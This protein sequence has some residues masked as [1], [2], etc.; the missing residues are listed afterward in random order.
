I[1]YRDEALVALRKTARETCNMLNSGTGNF[2]LCHGLAGN[3]EILLY[4]KHVLGKEPVSDM[5]DIQLVTDVA[6]TGI[7][8]HSETKVPWPC[9]IQK[10][11]PPGL[12]TGLSG[13]GYF[14]LRLFDSKKNPSILVPI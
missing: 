12:M 7:E 9:G 5:I 6:N 4:G 13:I 11:E 3:C 2:S 8:K 1:I 14:Y 10:G